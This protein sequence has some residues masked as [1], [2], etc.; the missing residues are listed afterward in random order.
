MNLGSGNIFDLIILF[1]AIQG[2]LFSVFVFTRVAENRK[3]NLFLGLFILGFSLNSI[4]IAF[5]GLGIRQQGLG[6]LISALPFYCAHLIIA[7]FY[8]L[9][10]YLIFPDRK[11]SKQDY[12][13]FLPYLFQLGF[14]LFILGL[15]LFNPAQLYELATTIFAIYDLIDLT[16]V[17]FGLY[18]LVVSVLRLTRYESNLRENYSEVQGKSLA[19]LRRLI[20]WLGIIWILFAIP[21]VYEYASERPVLQ[22][23]YPMW[24]LTS[25]LIYWIGYSAYRKKGMFEIRMFHQEKPVVPEEKNT[26][27]EKTSAYYQRLMEL[28]QKDKLYLNPDLNLKMLADSLHLSPGYCSQIINQYEKKN[29]FDFVNAYRVEEV[30]GNL[31]NPAFQH[32]NLLGIAYESGFKSKSTFNLVFKKIT[33]LTPSAYKKNLKA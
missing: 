24:I 26:L 10:V 33:G 29:F 16:A 9:V 28:M 11:F 32:L 15:V 30:K 20:Y 3:A 4:H 8:F 17:V 13:F 22:M 12:L 1:G 19:W 2:L 18:V 7:A 31:Q 23:Y 27:S 6:D 25:V 21:T 5:E 14:Q